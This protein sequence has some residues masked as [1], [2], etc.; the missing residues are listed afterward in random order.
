[1]AGLLP[2]FCFVG[3]KIKMVHNVT[4]ARAK[5]SLGRDSIIKNNHCFADVS[6]FMQICSVT[7]SSTIAQTYLASEQSVR[8]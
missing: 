5:S 2:G 6:S 8:E 1:M 7:P 3:A 4:A